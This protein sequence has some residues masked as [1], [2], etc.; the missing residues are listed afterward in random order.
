MAE[1]LSRPTRRGHR[2]D[3]GDDYQVSVESGLSDRVRECVGDHRAAII[4]NRT[5]APLY[6]ESVA[7]AAGSAGLAP[8]RVIL[9]DGEQHKTLNSLQLIY[10]TL[11]PQKI[12]RSTPIIALGG[13]V[14]TDLAGFAAATLLRGLPLVS[15]PTSLLAMV[16]ASVGGKT[17]VNHAA[18]KNLIGAFYPPK[19][20]LIDPTVLTTLPARE[21]RGGLAECIK[22]DLIRDADHLAVMEQNLPKYLSCDVDALTELVVHNVRIKAAVVA[23]DPFEQGERAHLNFGHTFGHAFEKVTSYALSHGEAVAVGMIC[24]MRTAVGLRMIEQSDADRVEALIAAAGLPTGGIDADVE[25]LLDCMATDKKVRD[26]RL[27]F[28]LPSR[29]GAVVVRDD[30]P[31]PLVREVLESTTH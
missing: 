21:L 12:E 14:I 2:I 1:A 19:A 22:H 20:V 30:V 26:G 10:D 16:D 8:L 18:G 27:R 31:P 24:A 6:L 29:V 15:I 11:L 23:A 28:V 9:P 4:S 7:E 17:G 25:A 3:I 13:G 5:V